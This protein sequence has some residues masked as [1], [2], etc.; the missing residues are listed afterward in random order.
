MY[1]QLRRPR[2]SIFAN[3]GGPRVGPR[4]A[5]GDFEHRAGKLGHFLVRGQRAPTVAGF[6]ASSLKWASDTDILQSQ[7]NSPDNDSSSLL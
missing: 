3:S 5:R 4:H 2:R 7:E 6:G 1:L